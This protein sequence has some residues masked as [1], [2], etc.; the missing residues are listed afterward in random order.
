VA[1]YYKRSSTLVVS[2]D[3]MKSRDAPGL[4]FPWGYKF[5]ADQGYSHLGIIMQRRCDWFRQPDLEDYFDQLR[6]DGFFDQFE[7]VIFYGASMG[8]YGALSYAAAVPGSDVVAFS[9]QTSLDQKVVPFETRY[10]DGFGRGK[11]RK[12]RYADAVKGAQAARRVTVFADPT[13]RLDAA[14]VAR[15][16]K[17]NLVFA[18]CPSSGHNSARL[19]KFMGC[20]GDVVLQAF[21]GT[22]TEED[23]YRTWRANRSTQAL[24]RIILLRGIRAGH[25]DLVFRTLERLETSRPDWNFRQIESDV[26]ERLL[27]RENGFAA[28]MEQLL[29]A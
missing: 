19:M 6:E 4:I 1:L 27:E 15:L 14:H 22:L 16:P 25:L 8:G 12:S 20:L 24:A 2:F 26:I 18:R 7:R 29:R 17:E 23:F 10:R 5:I 9:P 28:D 11:W 21:D 13:H 3:N